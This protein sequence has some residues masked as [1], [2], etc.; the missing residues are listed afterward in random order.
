MTKELINHY[1]YELA[2]AP[3]APG[4]G[5]YSVR[6]ILSDDISPVFPYL[7][8][9]L[10]DTYFDRENKILIGRDKQRQYAFRETDIRVAG[11]NEASQASEA[12]RK[13][14]ALVNLVWQERATITPNLAERK[15]PTAMDIYKHL[16]KTNCGQ[17]G[18]ATCLV[19]ASE[20]RT[21]NCMLEQCPPLLL[22]E[23]VQSL[24]SIRELFSS[25]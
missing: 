12:A 19:F 16:P 1:E 17:C 20:L 7:N 10:E 15:L 11:I 24:E 4:S 13:A 2:E 9:V 18:Y 6:I 14:V 22:Q 25:G 21:A 8:S 5:R 3:C 23:N